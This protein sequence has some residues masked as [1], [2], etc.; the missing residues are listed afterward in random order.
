[1]MKMEKNIRSLLISMLILFFAAGPIISVVPSQAQIPPPPIHD[2]R[3]TWTLNYHPG[4]EDASTHIMFINFFDSTSGDFE[5][6]GRETNDPTATWT[7]SGNEFWDSR[8]DGY[9]VT[10]TITYTAGPILI[11]DAEGYVMPEGD[12]ITQ[13]MRLVDWTEDPALWIAI[14]RPANKEFDPHPNIH[15]SFPDDDEIDDVFAEVLDKPKL[16]TI[17]GQV[18][19]MYEIA[20]SGKIISGLRPVIFRVPAQILLNLGFIDEDDVRE[21]DVVYYDLPSD[22]NLDGQV[23][24]RDLTQIMYRLGTEPGDRRW[25]PRCD[26]DYDAEITLDDWIICNRHMGE[27]GEWVEIPRIVHF[28]NRNGDELD[29]TD[30]IVLICFPPHFSGWGIRR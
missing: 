18:V 7:I 11:E 21:L 2:L 4:K 5:G 6:I 23:T 12:P 9:N 29:V 20:V 8:T 24:G 22:I 25:D 26:L 10:F 19:A 15:L 30:I 3:G 14:K 28:I 1:M 27:T 13:P 17:A 16:P